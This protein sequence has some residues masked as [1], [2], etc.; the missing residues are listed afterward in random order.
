[1]KIVST[2]VVASAPIVDERGTGTSAPSV[3]RLDLYAAITDMSS[4][5]LRNVDT[6]EL[7]D[8]Y[9]SPDE[10]CDFPFNGEALELSAREADAVSHGLQN[11]AKSALEMDDPGEDEE[12][13]RVNY[14]FA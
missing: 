2:S 12:S 8:E 14:H 4:V 6:G 13:P 3:S 1:M 10:P 5:R 7:D 11:L 9:I